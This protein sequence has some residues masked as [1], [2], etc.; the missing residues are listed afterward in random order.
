[1]SLVP[2]AV[3]FE[4]KLAGLSVTKYSAGEDVLTA[5]SSTGKLFVL[6]KGAVEVVKDGV[7]IAKIAAPGAVLGEL[8]VLLDQPHTADVRAVEESEFH[9][10]DAPALI[11]GDPAV[12][13]YVA[14][15]LA[16]RLDAANQALVEIKRQL[17][18]GDPRRAIGRTVDQVAAL[19]SAAG[20]VSLVYAGYP[21]DPL[22]HGQSGA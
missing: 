4:E 3:A 5:G 8:S 9:V 21:Y 11:A 17:E 13:L 1:M 2:D 18:A 16:R 12:A 15:L 10:A 7:P 19:L 20:G 22:A 14:A 6:R